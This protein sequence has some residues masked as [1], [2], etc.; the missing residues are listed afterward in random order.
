MVKMKQ[1][2]P[3][4][5]SMRE[6]KRYLVFEIIGKTVSSTDAYKAVKKAVSDFLGT[7]GT[8]G[9]GLI[10]INKY[11][12]NRGTIR[13][14]HRYVNHVRAALLMITTIQE[15]P[16]IVRSIGTSGILKKADKKYLEG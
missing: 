14:N 3:L 8:A 6:R 15:T 12:N 10:S 11:K 5:P 9:A 4:M 13:L 2:K 7:I 1:I 16:V